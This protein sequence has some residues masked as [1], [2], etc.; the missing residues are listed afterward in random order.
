MSKE[1]PFDRTPR[2]ST[3][4]TWSVRYVIGADR[5]M[6]LMIEDETPRGKSF[7]SVLLTG[8]HAREMRRVMLAMLEEAGEATER[9]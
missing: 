8:R 9:T 5:R 1:L 2:S 7:I 4:G 3:D 6:A